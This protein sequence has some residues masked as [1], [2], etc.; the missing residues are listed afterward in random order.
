MANILYRIGVVDILQSAQKV[1][2][3]WRKIF[4]D[5]AM[6]RVVYMGSSSDLNADIELDAMCKHVVDR[7][8]G[9]LVDITIVEFGYGEILLNIADRSSQLKRLT[10]ACCDDYMYYMWTESLK[11][12]PLLEELSLYAT[13]ISE[14][15]IETAGRYCSML[16]TLK[17]NYE[18]RRFWDDDKS[19][20]EYDKESYMESD[21]ES[22]DEF[23]DR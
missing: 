21:D 14:E 16:K 9:Q 7:S 5:P 15:A 18:D 2:T 11:K 8:Q 20:E 3:A 1:C 17:V 19:D 23:D 6:W 13:I 22:D 12:L 10:I 4:K